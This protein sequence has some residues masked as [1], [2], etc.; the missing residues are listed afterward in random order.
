[1]NSMSRSGSITVDIAYGRIFYALV[2]V[3]QIGLRI[4]RANARALVDAGM[5]IKEQINARL[6]VV[7]PEIPEIQGVAFVMFRDVEAD[8]AVRTCTTTWPGR[9]DRS[10]CGTGSAAHLATLY[11]RGE[12]KPGHVLTTRS[13]IDTEFEVGL[14]DTTSVGGRDAI[15][16]T[17][18]GRGWTFG[19]HQIAL[20]PTDPLA[21]GFALTDTWGPQAGDI[22]D[23]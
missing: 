12:I 9:V 22:G 13:I 7:H 19:L 11:A 20:D 5:R 1:M 21:H 2:D 23:P 10:P 4:E 18:T 3:D 16:P 17:I 6:P 14:H 15:I 8:G